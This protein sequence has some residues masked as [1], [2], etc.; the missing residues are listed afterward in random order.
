[1]NQYNYNINALAEK[2]D[3]DASIK[4]GGRLF[5]PCRDIISVL[6]EGEDFYKQPVKRIPASVKQ[7]QEAIANGG[8]VSEEIAAKELSPSGSVKKR[9]KK[10]SGGSSKKKKGRGRK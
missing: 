6:S 1:M 8:E 3:G 9:G 4:D 7:Y 10:K 5:K 2:Y